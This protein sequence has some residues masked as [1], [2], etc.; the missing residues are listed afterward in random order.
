MSTILVIKWINNCWPMKWFDIQIHEFSLVVNLFIVHS[1]FKI[2]MVD[3]S[4]CIFRIQ[5]PFVIYLI[6]QIFARWLKYNLI[7]SRFFFVV[8]V[9]N[10][11]IP[12][13]VFVSVSLLPYILTKS[14]KCDD[15]DIF[16]E[17][18]IIQK[19]DKFLTYI[20]F[21]LFFSII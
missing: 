1:I 11:T 21:I 20:N 12:V 17:A 18:Q 16:K 14:E 15:S 2:I 13:F 4:V 8:S 7:C 19:L 3:L 6:I 9:I 10:C 5:W